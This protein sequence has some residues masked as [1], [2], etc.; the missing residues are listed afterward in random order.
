[1]IEYFPIIFW[2]NYYWPTGYWQYIETSVPE[3]IIVGDIIPAISDAQWAAEQCAI[4]HGRLDALR[5][6]EIDTGVLSGLRDRTINTDI[7]S[8]LRRRK[9]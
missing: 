6:R 2:P 4:A 5:S 9:I 8:P 1:M 3:V 7:L